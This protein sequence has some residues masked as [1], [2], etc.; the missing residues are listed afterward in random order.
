MPRQQ[1][2]TAYFNQSALG[3]GSVSG[4]TIIGNNVLG[5]IYHNSMGLMSTNPNQQDITTYPNLRFSTQQYG[6]MGNNWQMGE[7]EDLGP[8]KRLQ[9]KP[10]SQGFLFSSKR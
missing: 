7:I 9:D 3:G 2:S 4:G 5:S 1:I 8:S 6:L 10:I